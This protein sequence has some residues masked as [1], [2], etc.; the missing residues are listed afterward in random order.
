MVASANLEHSHMS[1]C[2]LRGVKR[3]DGSNFELLEICYSSQDQ[4]CIYGDTGSE[5]RE[6]LAGIWQ[7]PNWRPVGRGK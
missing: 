3:M 1:T 4:S 2:Q 5:P 7:T 6:T